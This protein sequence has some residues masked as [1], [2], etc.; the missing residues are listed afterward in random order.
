MFCVKSLIYS[1]SFIKSVF[2]LV[3][4]LALPGGIFLVEVKLAFLYFNVLSSDFILSVHKHVNSYMASTC[5]AGSVRQYADVFTW[6]PEVILVI[7]LYHS[8]RLCSI[9][10]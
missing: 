7:A 2:S 6:F 9:C 5:Q 1:I 4:K 8:I 10:Y 3:F